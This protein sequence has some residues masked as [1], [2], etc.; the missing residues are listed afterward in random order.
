LG[1]W[2]G[3]AYQG[4]RSTGFGATEADRLDELR[5]TAAEDLIESRL[6]GSDP[7]QLVPELEA[8]VREE[9][10]RER[11]WAQ[12]MVALYRAERQAEALQAFTRAREVLVGELAMEPGPELQ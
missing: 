7:G 4:Y 5:R 11:R 3:D 10:L 8:M 9:P 6:A 2:R 12:L 1:L